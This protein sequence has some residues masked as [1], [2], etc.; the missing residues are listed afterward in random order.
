MKSNRA[1]DYIEYNAHDVIKMAEKA[2]EE[3]SI[4]KPKITDEFIR[5]AKLAFS[6]TVC[7]GRVCFNCTLKY[8]ILERFAKRLEEL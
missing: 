3:A 6:E 7:E 8:C 1:E 2:K 5:K 4:A